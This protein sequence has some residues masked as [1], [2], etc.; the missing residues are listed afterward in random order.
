MSTASEAKDER[1]RRGWVWLLLLLLLL[2]VGAA[3]YFF[4]V[5]KGDGS[6]RHTF[7]GCD[8][9]DRCATFRIVA[10][11]YDYRW[12]Y[13]KMSLEPKAGAQPDL[14]AAVSKDLEG[15]EIVIAAGLASR[16]GDPQLNRRLSACRSKALSGLLTSSAGSADLHRIALGRYEADE[17]DGSEL[18]EIER[19][20]V[21]GAVLEQDEG[22]DL[23]AAL[24]DGVEKTLDSALAKA[25]A[26]IA[27]QL[28]FRR[29]DCWDDEFAIT[30]SDQLLT[31]CYRER[32]SDIA[33]YCYGF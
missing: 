18:P 5:M 7:K 23:E 15:A 6:F 22:V 24:K 1:P 3:Y 10:P 20:V 26:P 29:Y 30:K 21:L 17:A 2:G 14:S 19:L 31:Q 4:V 28:D 33:A 16:E 32:T 9:Q 25:L 11:G 8:A 13:G 12:A 27:R